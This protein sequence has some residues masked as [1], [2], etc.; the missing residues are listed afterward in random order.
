[1]PYAVVIIAADRLESARALAEGEFGLPTDVAAQEFV[2]AGS[3]TGSLP[4][5]HYWLAT[6]FTD[7]SFAK[8]KQLEA[9]V[10]WARTEAYNLDTEPLK[11]WAVLAEMDLQP[12]THAMP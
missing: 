11:P 3:P 4:A 10:G 5:T 6:K 7:E 1:M 8:L 9:L 2:P 12:L